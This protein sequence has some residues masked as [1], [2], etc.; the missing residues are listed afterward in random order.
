MPG[1]PMKAVGLKNVPGVAQS[2]HLEEGTVLNPDRIVAT[3][4]DVLRQSTRQAAVGTAGWN[5][6]PPRYFVG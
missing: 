2:E 4:E 3:I 1:T 5:W 6:V